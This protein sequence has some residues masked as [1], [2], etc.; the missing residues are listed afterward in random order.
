MPT[1]DFKLQTSFEGGMDSSIN[2]EML[3]DNQYIQAM[4]AVCRG[5]ILR[6]RPG[7]W[8]V[9]G[10]PCGQ[11]QGSTLFKTSNGTTYLITAVNGSVYWS[12]QPFEYFYK[13]EGISF[14]KQAK[15]VNFQTCIQTT[16]R[17]AN[18]DLQALAKPK[19]VLMMQDG[20]TR[21]AFFDG[22]DARHTYP[23]LDKDNPANDEANETPLGLWM[24]WVGNRLAV[25]RG[26]QV[27]LSDYGNPLK[28]IEDNYLNE[29]PVFSM[30]ETVTGMVQPAANSP[31]I[32]FG[33]TTMTTLRVD[34][35]VR[36]QWSQV[37]DFQRTDT[38]VGCIAG[39]SIVKSH[40]LVW[41]MSM[42][43]L[44][45]LNY[46]L[47][48]N[49]DSRFRYIDTPMSVSKIGMSPDR[50][51]ICAAKYENYLLFSVPSGHKKNTH[52]WVLDLNPVEG[53]NY[54]WASYWTG[55]RPV[56][57]ATGRVNGDERIFA[58]SADD[59]GVNRVWEAFR[60]ERNDNGHPITA[61]V[62]FPRH[63][64]GSKDLKRYR[65]S[66]LHLDEVSGTADIGA[67][68]AGTKSPYSQILSKRIIATHGMFEV[69]P[70]VTQNDRMFDYRSQSRVIKTEEGHENDPLCMNDVETEF[71]AHIDRAFSTLVV[72]SGDLGISAI[73]QFI[74]D[75]TGHDY[76]NGAV[77]DDEEGFKIV[78]NNGCAGTDHDDI[79]TAFEEYEGAATV[80]MS[81][82]DDESIVAVGIGDGES[83]ISELDA[84]KKAEAFAKED[85][86]NFIDCDEDII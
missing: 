61:F 35:Q 59:D 43:G 25:A 3:R 66:E 40:G 19:P 49:N 68:Y 77:E 5:G 82:L 16:Y 83:L 64:H 84:I 72:W 21:P 41:W 23:I 33:E 28:F 54:A 78:A 55:I 46:A 73:R 47:Q 24:A 65:Y 67:F 63:A 37:A 60:P 44:T 57:W 26:E 8:S 80:T 10:M 14:Y 70:T 76:Y 18:G 20:F 81:C 4:N 69:K 29:F 1:L 52:T 42:S 11:A 58:L 30:P 51:T 56:E 34:I 62:E 53:G 6:T 85:A 7:F 9:F 36:S 39:K 31:L 2:P 38:N 79:G 15:F 27:F 71:P 32:V 13:F 75:D 50:N 12:R 48:L 74:D 45:N 86:Y 22:T 17:D